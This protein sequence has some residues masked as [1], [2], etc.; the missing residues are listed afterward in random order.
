MSPEEAQEAIGLP[1]TDRDPSG[2]SSWEPRKLAIYFENGKAQ[3]IHTQDPTVV[4]QEGIHVGS[5]NDDLIKA[6]GSPVCKSVQKVGPML[7]RQGWYYKGVYFYILWL[8]MATSGVANILTIRVVPK[9]D[10]DC[11]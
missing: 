3:I 1:P 6:Y 2:W 5:T 9:A 4:T 10:E 7:E 8:P 11:K